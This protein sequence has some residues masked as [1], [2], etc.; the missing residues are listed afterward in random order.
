MA[1]AA[2]FAVSLWLTHIDIL[3]VETW[4]PEGDE[5][6]SVFFE[7]DY[8]VG[9]ELTEKAEIEDMIR[10][11][12]GALDVRAEHQGMFTLEEDGSRVRY[13]EVDENWQDET[14]VYATQIGLK[15]ELESGKIVRRR[16]FVWA[17]SEAGNIAREYL[18]RWKHV[19]WQ[20]MTI[21]GEEQERLAYVMENFSAVMGD[22]TDNR[23]DLPAACTDKAKAEE[24]LAAIQ[25]DCAEG[26]MAQHPYF[27]TG[28]FRVEDEYE[29]DGIAERPNIHLTITSREYSWY[30]DIFADAKHTLKWL[31]DNGLLT[32]EVRS[33]PIRR[34]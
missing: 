27:H 10:L 29:E 5:V 11:H 23:K 15:Y 7:S 8:T 16:Y 19:N 33:E 24:L 1:L 13:T 17:D 9:E 34:W 28:H 14:L 12:Q 32:W 31:E 3:G 6:K 25:R 18:S 21:D 20:T 26:N 2:V 22:F 30:V 4:I